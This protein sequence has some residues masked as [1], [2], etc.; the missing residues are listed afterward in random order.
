M[1]TIVELR[2]IEAGTSEQV[3]R[4]TR[5]TVYGI[6]VVSCMGLQW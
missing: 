1:Q 5:P 4:K 3:I 2:K 6:V